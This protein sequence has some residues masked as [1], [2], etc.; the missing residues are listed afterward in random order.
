MSKKL[1]LKISI[2]A[3]IAVAFFLVMPKSEVQYRKSFKYHGIKVKINDEQPQYTEQQKKE[4]EDVIRNIAPKDTFNTFENFVNHYIAYDVPGYGNVS[5][6]FGNPTELG[7]FSYYA[8][9][10]PYTGHF[11]VFVY[12]TKSEDEFDYHYYADFLHKEISAPVFTIY[13]ENNKLVCRDDKTNALVYTL[14]TEE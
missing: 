4:I 2:V 14:D 13:K 3:V 1:L 8:L 5:G 6:G 12:Y 10:M 7:M 11:R 9:Q